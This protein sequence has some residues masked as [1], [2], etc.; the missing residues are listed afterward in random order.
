M[1]FA[2]GEWNGS[3]DASA[4]VIG[5]GGGIIVNQSTS[6]SGSYS[7]Q[8]SDKK[9]KDNIGMLSSLS[10]T[11]Y[12]HAK[13][14][15]GYVFTGWYNDQ[16]GTNR[17]SEANYYSEKLTAN[18]LS[19][20]KSAGPYYA[21]FKQIIKPAYE[22]VVLYLYDD[23]T[24]STF[25]LSVTLNK[26]TALSITDNSNGLLSIT[27]S[28]SPS[29]AEGQDI[30]LNITNATSAVGQF[31]EGEDLFTITLTPSNSS[32]TNTN[33][34]NPEAVKISVS[35]VKVATVTFTPPAAGGSYTYLQDN[36]LG[37]TIAVNEVKTATV[38]GAGNDKMF[39]LS[40]T[41]VEEGYRFRR[42]VI[43]KQVGTPEYLYDKV[44]THPIMSSANVTAEFVSTDYAQFIVLPDTAKHYAHMDDA[45]EAAKKLGKTVVSVY[46]PGYVTIKT[47]GDGNATSFTKKMT[48]SEWILPK[49]A[50]GTYLIPAGYTLLVP[51]L[52]KSS[53]RGTAS[54]SAEAKNL[55]Y[56]Y[57]LDKSTVDH[58]LE[59]NQIG[60]A[61]V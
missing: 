60:R 19:T 34:Y 21:F 32:I 31:T 42:W 56:T 15:K 44:A 13:A 7:S 52:E 51:G 18:R 40:V 3:L 45:F 8:A 23:G 61:H 17:K 54:V 26:T 4:S 25:P 41:N 47:N 5:V 33:T 16:N 57:L 6:P 12:F 35:V 39:T 59:T 29:G 38:M 20:S 43:N 24:L 11:F 53:L 9:T 10:T 36:G 37:Q 14:D 58:F 27:Q 28:D 46:Q 48:K 1:M 30:Q 55:G 22:E 2:W 49:P 50:S